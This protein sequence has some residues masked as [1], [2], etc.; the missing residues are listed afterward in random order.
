[1]AKIGRMVK[2]SMVEELASKLDENSTLFVTSVSRLS[3]ADSD[4]LRHKL[5]GAQARL[6]V[7]KN[8]LGKRVLSGMKVN[9]LSALGEVTNGSIGF[10]IAAGD[11]APVAKHLV[12]FIKDHAEHLAIQGALVEGQVFDK[13]NVE[14]FAALPPKP[15]LL[16]QVVLTIESPLADVVFTV[17]RLMGD[18]CWVVEQLA[19][20]KPAAA[21]S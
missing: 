5:F 19:E 13:K 14:A 20:K 15:A 11:A 2:D 6:R 7:M 4:A 8:T 18:V 21:A 16:A 10:V 17:E 9:N 3:S 1:M 12:D